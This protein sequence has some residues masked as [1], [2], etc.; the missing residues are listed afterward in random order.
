MSDSEFEFEDDEYDTYYDDNEA[1]TQTTNQKLAIENAYYDAEDK[2]NRD[3]EQAAQALHQLRSTILGHLQS[4]SSQLTESS[5][6]SWHVKV[7][8]SL[9]KIPHEDFQTKS[10]EFRDL[11]GALDLD[12]PS[13]CTNCILTGLEVLDHS[14]KKEGSVETNADDLALY[15]D[16]L[17]LVC[18]LAKKLGNQRLWQSA[19][20][21][22]TRLLLDNGKLDLVEEW[23]AMLYAEW[24]N[25]KTNAPPPVQ[26]PWDTPEF[27]E[28]IAASSAEEL[29]HAFEIIALDFEYSDKTGVNW[30]LRRLIRH[31]ENFSRVMVNRRTLSTLKRSIAKYYFE[32]GAFDAA[33]PNLFDAWEA[34]FSLGNIELA[35]RQLADLVICNVMCG[36]QIDPLST[37]EA[38]TLLSQSNQPAKFSCADGSA[39]YSLL[40]IIK[41]LDVI[42]KA[43]AASDVK[44][45]LEAFDDPKVQAFLETSE[46]THDVAVKR[47]LVHKARQQKFLELISLWIAV[48]LE[49]LQDQLQIGDLGDLKYFIIGMSASVPPD[50]LLGLQGGILRVMRHNETDRERSALLESLKEI[51]NNLNA[52]NLYVC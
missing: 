37:R 27:F 1:Q 14:I 38:H 46:F 11:L 12:S 10:S 48:D 40:E 25:I 22:S 52:A 34:N 29:A 15:L 31:C 43:F 13:E 41:A 39:E 45:L 26:R 4:G 16:L 18:D 51:C 3:P 28:R 33:Y 35:Q 5:L 17:N 20:L 47:H 32:R 24:M 7:L 50:V 30:R 23:L 19:G 49:F 6:K 42:K 44:N 2:I 9:L 36:S 21:R 8:R